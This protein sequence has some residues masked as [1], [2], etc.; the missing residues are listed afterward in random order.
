MRHTPTAPG[1][2]AAL[3]TQV[4]FDITRASDL[5]LLREVEAWE[6]SLSN[7]AGLQLK[8]KATGA[9]MVKSRFCKM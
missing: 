2:A 9:Q 5:T 3:P 4:S 6:A 7:G 1:F 8:S